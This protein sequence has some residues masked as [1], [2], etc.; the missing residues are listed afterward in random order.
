LNRLH[1]VIS[2]K[3]ELFVSSEV[4]K[5]RNYLEKD[6]T[7]SYN[8]DDVLEERLGFHKANS[9]LLYVQRVPQT[10][11][12]TPSYQMFVF[13]QA[14]NKLNLKGDGSESPLIFRTKLKETTAGGGQEPYVNVTGTIEDQALKQI[15]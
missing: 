7:G 15:A 12:Y 9:G 1:G 4:Q 13:S 6:V 14:S 2:Q 11:L 10:K 3:I 5:P 8:G